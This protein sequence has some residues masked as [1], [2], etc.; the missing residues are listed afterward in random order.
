M[1][2]E[3]IPSIH[4]TLKITVD[5]PRCCGVCVV[6]VVYC[7]VLVLV[8][9]DGGVV[10]CV[11]CCVVVWCGVVWCGVVCVWCGLCVWCFC[12]VFLLFLSILFFLFLTLSLSFSLLS[13]FSLLS[14]LLFSLPR[15]LFSS[16]HATKHC[17]KNRS[18]NTAANWRTAGAQQSVLSPPLHSLLPSLLLLKKIRELFITGKFPARNFFLLRF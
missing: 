8:F 18:T 9:G 14:S 6:C 7:V 13:F 12:V 2:G 1:T 10:C 5:C 16:L 4:K 17:G 11:L 3:H 15:F